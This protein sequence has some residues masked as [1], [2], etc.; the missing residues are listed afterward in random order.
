MKAPL[1]RVT[2]GRKLVL[3]TLAA[4]LAVEL[5][6]RIWLVFFASQEQ[7]FKLRPLTEVPLTEQIYR[8]HP[9]T[10]YCLNEVYRSRD[11]RN[12]HNSHGYRGD[13]ITQ[14][15]PA[16]T[17]RILMLGGSTTYETGIADWR[18]TTTVQMQRLLGERAGA[19]PVEVI[20]AGCG[21][22]NS[23]ESL[24][25]LQF[26][27]LA[28]QPDLVIVYCGTNEVHAR[29]VPH[30]A[31]KRDGSGFRKPWSADSALWEHSLALRWCALRL[32]LIPRN[33]VADLT[34]IDHGKK[35]TEGEGL[36]ELNAPSYYA[37][38]L[39]QMIAL[40]RAKGVGIVLATWASCPDKQDYAATPI[41]QR[42][43]A[44]INQTTRAVAERSGALLYDHAPEMPT[45]ERYWRDGNHVNAEGARI[46][47]ELFAR[48]LEQHV[49]QR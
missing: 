46:K 26:R 2:R 24:I 38:N 22:W 34:E 23:W 3:F 39:E 18:E 49:L 32:S 21:G 37:D 17:Y 30:A 12:R 19:R 11:G 47:A 31:Y 5:G 45:D 41:Y 27:G 6:V 33:S 43:F 40:C 10:A 16:G 15:K 28:L 36:L 20:N 9:Y 13:E 25:D 29:L 42:G 8:A 44:E 7:A 35:K 14:P 4:W 1:F 48:Y